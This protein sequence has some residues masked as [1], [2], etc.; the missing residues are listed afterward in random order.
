VAKAPPAKKS[1]GGGMMGFF[2]IMLIA[3]GVYS[4]PPIRDAIARAANVILQPFFSIF[5]NEPYSWLIVILVL[6]A[7]TGLYSSLLQK[8]T[9]DY[10]KM[11]VQ[12]QKMKDFQK[13]FREAQLSGD[14]K[15]VRKLND[16]REKLMEDQMA[17]SQEQFKPMGWIMLITVPIWIWLYWTISNFP[18]GEVPTITFPYW[19]ELALSDP[20]ALFLPAWIIWYMICSLCLSQ[21]IRKGLNIGGL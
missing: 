3:M 14:E 7:L 19:G 8:Y 17:M 11:Q 1:V 12:Q 5:G 6:S 20:T 15:A 16:K 9:I 10:E 18:V 4:I 13:V 21:V 2:I